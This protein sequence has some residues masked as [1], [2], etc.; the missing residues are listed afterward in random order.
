MV[1]LLLAGC[2]TAEDKTAQTSPQVDAYL[3]CNR[4][5]SQAVST[6]AGDP[7]S[8]A[9]A[10]RSLCPKEELALQQ[11]VF[12]AYNVAT[13][14]RIYEMYRQRVIEDNTGLIVTFRARRATR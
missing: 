5:A 10:A 1:C 9:V 11:S 2:V 8:L 4:D 6:Q 7:I 12:A 13:A 3:R 14:N